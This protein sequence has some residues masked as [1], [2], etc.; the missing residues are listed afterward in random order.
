MPVVPRCRQSR[1]TFSTGSLVMAACRAAFSFS[2]CS[3]RVWAEMGRGI[4]NVTE[5][6][7]VFDGS[8]EKDGNDNLAKTQKEEEGGDQSVSQSVKGSERTIERT[9][10]GKKEKREKRSVAILA[11][12]RQKSELSKRYRVTL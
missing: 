6:V 7:C 9:A 5:E 8:F 12:N 11:S 3:L 2:C 10:E 1:R 4:L